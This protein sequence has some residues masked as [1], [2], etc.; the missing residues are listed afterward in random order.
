MSVFISYR[1]TDTQQAAGR[2]A[3]RLI[4]R[5]GREA[6]VIDVDTDQVGRD[7][8]TLISDYL[9]DADLVLA[10]IGPRFMA[11][12]PDGTRRLDQPHD[13]LRLELTHALAREVPVVPVLVDDAELPDPDDL[14]DDLRD[15][16]FFGSVDLAHHRF[17]RDYSFLEERVARFLEQAPVSAGPSGTDES[18]S[19]AAEK[20]EREAAEKAAAEKA[21]AEKAER[22]AAEKAE[23]EAA[24]KAA[25]EKAEREAAEKVERGPAEKAAAE[26]LTRIPAWGWLALAVVIAG[27]VVGVVILAVTGGSADPTEADIAAGVIAC[28]N[29]DWEACDDLVRWTSGG[30][31][32]WNLGATCGRRLSELRPGE[33][34]AIAA[35]SG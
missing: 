32:E 31:V 9:E 6:V 14:P 1:R 8:R 27:L 18:P 22:E 15:L 25:V 7:Y 21:A 17:D 34:V 2:L 33:C 24:E 19:A 35:E 20:V 26:T 12:G 16:V 11:E 4:E 23:R 28:E 10:L 29:G 13:A 5:F 30:S 3:D